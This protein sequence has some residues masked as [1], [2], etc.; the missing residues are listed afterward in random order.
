MEEYF[1]EAAPGQPQPATQSA[2]PKP[3]NTV[4]RPSTPTSDSNKTADSLRAEKSPNGANVDPNKLAERKR[5]V[6]A[7]ICRQVMA[8]KVSAMLGLYSGLMGIIKMHISSYG[9][10]IGQP[11]QPQQQQPAQ[12]Q[13]VQQPVQ[14]QQVVPNQV[15]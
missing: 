6:M 7:E 9:G 13:K 4:N 11:V 2:N 10:N 5:Q 12:P 3:V 14:Q 8:A 15:Q 1:G